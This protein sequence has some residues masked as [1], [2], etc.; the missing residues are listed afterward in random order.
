MGTYNYHLP[1][2]KGKFAKVDNEDFEVVKDFNWCLSKN[3]YA[4]SNIGGYMHRLIM[5]PP[6]DMEVDHIDRNKLDNRRY[7][8]RICTHIE[9]MRYL[10]STKY[11]HLNKSHDRKSKSIRD[12]RKF[13]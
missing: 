7:N 5:N 6:K 1:L 12:Y 3:G 4:F 13:P 8:L 10:H 9:N 11:N 2:S